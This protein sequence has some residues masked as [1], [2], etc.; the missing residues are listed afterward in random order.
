M[1][2]RVQHGIFKPRQLLNLHTSAPRFISPLPTNPIDALKNHNWKMT[3]KDENDA[4]I[5]NKMC[6]LVP[7]PSNSNNKMC[8]L[9]TIRN[10]MALLS[11]KKLV[12]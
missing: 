12:L 7:R 9:G 3:M 8:Y 11:V 5:N 10:Q 4:L 2:T 6:Y 1:T